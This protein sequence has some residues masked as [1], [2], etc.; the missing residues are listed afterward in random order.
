MKF[1]E[2]VEYCKNLEYTPKDTDKDD[3]DYIRESI[4]IGLHNEIQL[5][6]IFILVKMFYP[7]KV[8]AKILLKDYAQ[9][10]K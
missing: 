2:L 5:K 1:A 4:Y 6:T 7:I 9:N 3:W 8:I 10:V